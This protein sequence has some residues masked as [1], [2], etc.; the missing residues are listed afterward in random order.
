QTDDL[1]SLSLLRNAPT[2]FALLSFF[3][4]NRIN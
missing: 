3:A 1:H 4:Q 2:P